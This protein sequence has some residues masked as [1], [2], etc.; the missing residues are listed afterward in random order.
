[1]VDYILP[2]Y[3]TKAVAIGF[4]MGANVISC[5]LGESGENQEKFICGISVC[6]GYDIIQ[7][8]PLLLQW[9][10]L[11]RAYMFRLAKNMRALFARH[12]HVLFSE[13]VLKRHP[14]INGSLPQT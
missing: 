10:Q 13:E 14:L 7:S 2:K 12:R 8:R 5:Y 1:M 6:Q 3:N 11:R 9:Q 4:S